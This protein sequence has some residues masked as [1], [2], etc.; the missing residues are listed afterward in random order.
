MNG[1]T[2]LIAAL[3]CFGGGYFVYSRFLAKLLGVDAGRPTPAVSMKD[4]VDYVPAPPAVLFGHHFA[5]IAGAG[6]IVGP[7]LAAQFGWA[8][9]ALW[10]V[11]G[12]VFIGAAHDMIAMFLSVRHKGESIGSVIGTV[13][14]RP[15]RILF[16]TFCW[17]TLVLV[18]AEFVRQI[19][20]TFVMDPGIATAS[21]LFILEAVVFGVCVYRLRMG[22]LAASLIFVPL[23]F[24]FVWVGTQFPLDLA[25]MCG[26]SAEE[27]RTTWTLVLLGYCFLAS[28]APVWLLLQPRDYL[29]A[30]LLYA[31]MAMGLLGVVAA[32]PELNADAFAGWTAM[33]RLGNPETLF[34]FLFVTVACG[35]CSGFHA[36]V[37]SGTS[38]KQLDSERSIRPVAYGGM[39]LEGAL[40]IIALIGVAGTY[41]SQS[42]YMAAAKASEPVQIFAA[43]I[44]GFCGKTGLPVEAAKSFMLL[45]VSAFLMTSVDSGTR[46]ARFSWQELAGSIAPEKGGERSL[47][48]KLLGSMYTG[49]GVAV[50]VAGALLLGDPG[51]AKSLW[52]IFASANQL[53]AALTLLTATLWFIRKR[54]PCWVTLL[55][56][57][58]MMSVS[59]YALGALFLKALGCRDWARTGATGFLI[60]TAIALVLFM[61][62][63]VRGELRERQN[64]KS[65]VQND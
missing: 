23:M 45:A 48:L 37:A 20:A 32:R 2:L 33:N 53:L 25:A 30:Y 11:L 51:T 15:G 16:L 64:G 58:F 43:T 52:T 56:M 10:V 29:N 19:A 5:T 28:T 17:S 57:C 49:T 42:E 12:C 59:T 39:L 60:L 55:P 34:P 1:L 47:G 24:G 61:A 4:G 50:G 27:A 40:A 8:S 65:E 31:M 3:A 41:A 46:L 9:V 35:A 21:L 26:M 54:K 13:L 18:V 38:A 62:A 14:G 36:L 63:K 7:V 44:A 22:V 6:P